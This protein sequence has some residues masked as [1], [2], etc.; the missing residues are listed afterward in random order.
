MRA[1]PQVLPALRLPRCRRAVA[2]GRRPAPRHHAPG[3]LRH[4]RAGRRRRHGPRLPRRAEGAR[5]HRRGEDHPPAPARGRERL[6]P[7]HH[8][9]PRREPPQP[10]ELRRR[11]RLRQERRA[12]LPRDGVPARQGPRPRGLRGGVPPLQADRRHHGAGARRARRGAPPRHH[13]PRSQ[14]REH[15]ARA[16]PLRRRLREGGR[17][18]P[19]QDEG[20]GAGPRHHQP[21]HRLR[22]AGLHGARSRAAAIP[23]TSAA[24]STPAASSSSSSS[25]AASPSRRR[26][27]RRWC[28]CTSRCRRPTRAW[29]RPTAT[30]PRASSR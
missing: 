19:R 2:Q 25:P 6:R 13:P 28:S 4:P 14:A 20:G 5:P 23:S 21:R 3:W 11:H 30:S 29:S 24:I 22:H 7:L 12:A 9:G 16:D 18:R 15:R 26:R 1:G 8:G 17:L 10:P 27:R